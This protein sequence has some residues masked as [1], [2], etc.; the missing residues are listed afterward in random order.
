MNTYN[1][2]TYAT[3]DPLVTAVQDNIVVNGFSLQNEYICTSLINEWNIID[4]THFD[5]PK[6]NWR[7]LLW[8]FNRGKKITLKT[9]IK[10]S[11]SSDFQARLDDLRKNIFKSE[12]NLDIKVD[13]VIRRI[14]VNCLSA[15]KIVNYFNI[16]FLEVNI[17]FETLEPFFYE[18]SNQT[19]TYLSKTTSFDEYIVNEWTTVSDPRIYFNFKTWISWTT[20]VA[21]TIWDNTIT[22][23]ETI[24][25]N[26]A[27]VVN[28]LEK[29]VKLNDVDVDYDWVFPFLNTDWNALNF[30]INW[31]FEVDINVI[32]K[33]N[34]V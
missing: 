7:G 15:P 21:L 25:D 9:I 16:T 30:V 10:W 20:S 4:F 19:S 29:T 18:L 5:Y 27:L 31:T 33:I 2:Q 26:D 11:S 1:S 3:W 6:T 22:I 28:G 8:Y 32:N 17:V 12:V 14:K 13:W 34:Y 24:S 23:N